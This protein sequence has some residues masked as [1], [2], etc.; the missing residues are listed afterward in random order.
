MT[1]IKPDAFHLNTQLAADTFFVG[2]MPLS[3]LLLMNNAELPWLILV[4]R[5]HSA[6]ELTD[7]SK[8]QQNQLMR[9]VTLAHALLADFNPDK[10]NTAAI[11]NLVSQLHMHV[12]AR[13]SDDPAWPKPVWGVLEPRPYSDALSTQRLTALRSKLTQ[14][15]AC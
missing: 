4:P 9:E 1:V 2:D 11:G 15:L 12:V 14:L 7:L 10:I 8:A 3:Q 5:I 13:Y 6:V